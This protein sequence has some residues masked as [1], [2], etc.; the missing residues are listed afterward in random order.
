MWGHSLMKTQM[1]SI[2][3]V[4]RL[5]LVYFT[6]MW[7]FTP[8]AGLEIIL[9]QKPPHIEIQGVA[10]KSYIQIKYVVKKSWDGI[11]HNKRSASHLLTLKNV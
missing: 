5:A 9:N 2:R 8:T 7:K 1:L 10:I 4:A 3:K 6:S 11:A